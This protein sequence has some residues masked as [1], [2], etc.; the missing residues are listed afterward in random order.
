M[1]AFVSSRY[2]IIEDLSPWRRRLLPTF[3]QEGLG[4]ETIEL[5]E[6][7]RDVREHRFH[8]HPSPG[9]ADPDAVPLEPELAGQPHGLASPVLEQF[10]GGTHGVSS[11]DIY[12]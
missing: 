7:R 2:V 9:A 4:G 8:E 1:H 6:P 12:H 3:R 11:V 5:G 10:G